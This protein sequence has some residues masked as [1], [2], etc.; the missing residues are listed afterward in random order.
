MSV[1]TTGYPP[2]HLD[3]SEALLDLGFKATGYTGP[4]STGEPSFS[5]QRQ[6]EAGPALNHCQYIGDYDSL[7]F[8]PAVQLNLSF[9]QSLFLLNWSNCGRLADLLARLFAP[10]CQDLTGE[11]AGLPV[12]EAASAISFVGNEL[13]ENA[14]KFHHNPALP[15]SLKVSLYPSRLVFQVSN[16]ISSRA[17]AAFKKYLRRVVNGDPTELLLEKMEENALDPAGN[18]SGLG[19][20]TILS[21]Y[22][23][24]AGWKFETLSGQPDEITVHSMVQLPLHEEASYEGN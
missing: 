14:L 8:A 11:Q 6:D 24:K 1:E 21:D 18:S 17:G 15:L 22:R 7:P 12:E 13:I 5:F 4:A 16:N 2:V 23:A 10:L 20:L 9:S 3:V 19:I